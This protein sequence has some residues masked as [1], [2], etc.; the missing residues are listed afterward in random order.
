MKKILVTGVA[1][2]IGFHVAKK[3]LSETGTE[4]IGLDN[5]NDYYPMTL[6]FERLKA[7][8]VH[9]DFV[10]YNQAI[11]G[12]EHERFKFVRMDLTDEKSLM[13]LFQEHAFDSVVHMA[14]QAGVRYS[15]DNPM[16]YIQ[17]NV[18]G[19]NNILEACRRFP[20]RHLV[21]ASSSSVY[22]LN[23]SLPFSV[24]HRVDQPAS[25]YAATKKSNE[26]MAHTYSHLFGIPTT[27]LRFFTVYGPWGRPDMAP[28]LFTKAILN[29]DAVN[30]YNNG[31]M[32]RDFTFV[33]DAANGVIKVL[34]TVPG[35]NENNVPYR[36]YNI[37]NSKPV[38]LMEFIDILAEELGKGVKMNLMPMQDGDVVSTYADISQLEEEVGYKPKTTIAQ[39]V[40]QF[41]RWY[42]DLYG[43]R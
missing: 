38:Q 33:D 29:G 15:I 43:R 37:G 26:L 36:V 35:P 12:K 8:G 42:L 7:L 40:R 5:I 34:G 18:V 16:A 1:G 25:V 23:K 41:V 2:F 10:R 19:F 11:R 27:G 31:K 3:L 9:P 22:G 32:A 4:I 14:A 20:V 39:G 13:D 30:V 6:K 21:Y 17:S 28:M 24:S